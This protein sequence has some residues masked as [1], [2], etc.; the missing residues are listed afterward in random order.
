MEKNSGWTTGG[1]IGAGVAVGLIF[2]GCMFYTGVSQY[3]G[4]T[5]VVTVKGLAEREVPADQV[6]WPITFK[7]TGDNLL[8]THTKV[9]ADSQKVVAFL[10]TPSSALGP[11]KFRTGTLRGWICAVRAI[12]SPAPLR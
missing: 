1:L 5:R 10:K 6:I 3:L 2:L 4:Q 8:T 11:R 9:E 12:R 7:E